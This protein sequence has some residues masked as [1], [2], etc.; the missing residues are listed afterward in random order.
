QEG[1]AR[2]ELST[3]RMQFRGPEANIG[4]AVRKLESD[5]RAGMPAATPVWQQALQAERL[6]LY[7]VHWTAAV[8]LSQGSGKKGDGAI[9]V[10][11]RDG[12]IL[13]LA[14]WSGAIRRGLGVYDVVYVHV[15]ESKAVERKTVDARSKSKPNP[16]GVPS[17]GQA[18][19]RV[20]PTV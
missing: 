5:N 17:G 3:G 12:R 10:G 4:D 20:R 15:V 18:Q 13:P 19:L 2:Y 16:A 8:V 9:R 11:L 7:D 1:L 6:P 14:L